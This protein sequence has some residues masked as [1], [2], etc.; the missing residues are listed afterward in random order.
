MN[1]RRAGILIVF[2]VITRILIF[3]QLPDGVTATQSFLDTIRVNYSS[4]N[5]VPFDLNSVTISSSVPI[6]VH[7]IKNRKGLAGVVTSNIKNSVSLANSYFKN[8]GLFF[9]IDSINYIDDYNYAFITYDKLRK[10]LLTKYLVSSR[11]NLFFVDSIKLG[12]ER[13][14]GFTHFPN[15][16][17]SNIIYLDKNYA[18]GTSL[19]TM[20]GHF[21]GLLST[22]EYRGGQEQRDE[23]NCATS[24]DFICDTRAD[25]GLFNQVIDSCNY[26]G[27]MRD[28][29]GKYFIP[30][31]ANVMSD[32][33]DKCKCI[34][35]TLQYRRI[36]YYFHKYRQYLNY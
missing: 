4:E 34:L 25:P 9:F 6:R 18:S 10:E 8:A 16:R 30:S 23:Q 19:T 24:G 21:M 28:N 33:P 22:H 35:T 32:S 36:F 3:G 26:I 11:I 13:V 1:L 2:L 20:L 7:I 27:T 17:D 29:H 15:V 31:V 14:Y 12:N 5:T